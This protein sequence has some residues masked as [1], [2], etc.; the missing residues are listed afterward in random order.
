MNILY[1]TRK[2]S[3]GIPNSQE[4][5]GKS[6]QY[7]DTLKVSMKCRQKSKRLRD[8]LTRIRRQILQKLKHNIGKLKV[9]NRFEVLYP[10]PLL[11][12]L[13]WDFRVVVFVFH[14]FTLSQFNFCKN[15]F[16]LFIISLLCW[17]M[18]YITDVLD[19]F[20]DGTELRRTE[21]L[22]PTDCSLKGVVLVRPTLTTLHYA[23]EL[24]RI[25]LDLE[26]MLD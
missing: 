13:Y 18:G 3:L 19:L 9:W 24:T 10:D 20:K 1:E 15:V 25:S 4:E 17:T 11:K 6:V 21:I 14:L 26:V 2:I 7:R 12:N 5:W 22:C 8:R 23:V 16:F